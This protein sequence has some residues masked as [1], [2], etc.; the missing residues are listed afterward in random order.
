MTHR[1]T[2]TVHLSEI[3]RIKKW[4][5]A[6]KVEHPLEYHAWDAVLT[7]WMMGWC[8]S[9]PAFLIDAWWALPLCAVAMVA[10]RLYVDWRERANADNRLRCDWLHCM[11]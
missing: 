1:L 5:V 11:D 2:Q 9:L 10:P 7:V 8:G 4:Q 6:H 3:Q